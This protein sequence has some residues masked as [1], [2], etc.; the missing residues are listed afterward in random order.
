MVGYRWRVTRL[1][2]VRHAPT[3]ETG[4]T[5]YG[6]SPGHSLSGTGRQMAEDLAQRLSAVRV[7]AVYSSPLERAM[8]TARPIA[9]SQRR[10][11]YPHEG[12]LEVDYGD[13]TGRSLKSLYRLKAWRTVVSNPSRVRFPGGESLVEAQTRAVRAC[14]DLAARH[15]RQTVAAVTHADL[16]RGV[17]SHLLGQ[18]LDLFERIGVAP[19][20]VTVI[21]LPAQGSPRITALNSNGES[22]TWR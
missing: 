20:S 9:D 18:P 15:R 6:R 17:V 16:I 12:L 2:L 22:T 14:E 4:K 21:D 8:E 7:A 10:Q 19:A 3:P 11:V 1:L 5:L 13:W